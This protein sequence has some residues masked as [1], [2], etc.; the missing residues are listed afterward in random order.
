MLHLIPEV[1]RHEYCL[2]RP[3]ISRFRYMIV[4]YIYLSPATT[5]NFVQTN[6]LQVLKWD[7]IKDE[8]T[9]TC[10]HEFRETGYEYSTATDLI[11]KG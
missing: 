3:T 2:L 8:T 11:Y 6:T 7:S 9:I 5:E 4:Y 1:I 10:K